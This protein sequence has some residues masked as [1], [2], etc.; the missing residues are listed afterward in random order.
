MISIMQT[1]SPDTLVVDLVLKMEPRQRPKLVW[2]HRKC[3]NI[4]ICRLSLLLLSIFMQQNHFYCFKLI[5]SGCWLAHDIVST[6]ATLC[7]SPSWS[8]W[9]TDGKTHNGRAHYHIRFCWVQR[10]IFGILVHKSTE[11]FSVGLWTSM[12]K[13]NVNKILVKSCC[14][15]TLKTNPLCWVPF[16]FL[17]LFLFCFT[18]S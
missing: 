11:F 15:S 10:L 9:D 1:V 4:S 2:E 8:L 17:W 7:W 12:P 16:K 13:K 14:E 18:E 5:S 6:S 3:G